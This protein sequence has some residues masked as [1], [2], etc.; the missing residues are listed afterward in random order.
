MIPN[1]TEV[2]EFLGHPDS[3]VTRNDFEMVTL[4]HANTRNDAIETIVSVNHK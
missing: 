2:I 3:H 4:L 1:H